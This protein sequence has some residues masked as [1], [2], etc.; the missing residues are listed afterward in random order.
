[1]V[2]KIISNKVPIVK[3]SINGIEA[4]LLVDTGASIN[5]IDSEKWKKF[6]F[7]EVKKVGE[8]AGLNGSSDMYTT[9]N[10]SVKIADTFEV[11]QFVSCSIAS[12]KQSILRSE[13]IEI[14]GIIGVPGQKQLEMKID[15][16][17]NIVILGNSY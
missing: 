14:D 13:G 16:L 11:V 12:A 15:V 3:A 9:K 5:M 2:I 6:G 1:M 17:N 10:V 8:V 4:N 7:V